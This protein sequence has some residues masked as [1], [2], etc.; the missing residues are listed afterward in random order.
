MGMSASTHLFKK[1]MGHRIP[2]SRVGAADFRKSAR[3]EFVTEPG[4]PRGR[5]RKLEAGERVLQGWSV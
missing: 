4:R 1:T 3:E 2:V 5:R